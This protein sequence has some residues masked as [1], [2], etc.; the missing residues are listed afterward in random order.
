WEGGYYILGRSLFASGRYQEVAA[1]AEA[2][3][4][5]CGDDHNVYVP[6]VNALG[7]L[8]KEEAIRNMSLRR[9]QA[10]EN[11]LKQVPDDARARAHL[12]GDYAD[13]G[14]HDDAMREVQFA[15]A[16]RPNDANLLYNAAC[17]YCRMA[18]KAEALDALSRAWDVGYKDS[19][20]ARR[21]PDLTMLRGDPEFE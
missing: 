9:M 3:I 20:W 16:L 18:R 7:A 13:L 21:D 2:A 15:V 1:M 6:I 8:G 14:R 5:A 10:L 12:A 11:H 19:V 17:V 4:E